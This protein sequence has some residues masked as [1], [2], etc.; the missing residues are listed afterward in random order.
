MKGGGYVLQQWPEEKA[1]NTLA[2]QGQK[3][4]PSQTCSYEATVC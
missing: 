3:N 1:K 4:M 2:Q